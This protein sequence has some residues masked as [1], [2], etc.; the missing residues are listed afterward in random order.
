MNDREHLEQWAAE[1][2]CPQCGFAGLVIE[3]RLTSKPLGSFSL[4]G[5]QMKVSATEL[6]WI[7]CPACGVEAEGK[8]E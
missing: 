5:S 3:W 1:Q 4:A 7:K 6:P 2:S 8:Q